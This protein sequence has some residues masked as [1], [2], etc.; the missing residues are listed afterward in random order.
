MNP[1]PLGRGVSNNS[2]RRDHRSVGDDGRLWLPETPPPSPNIVKL[3]SADCLIGTGLSYLEGAESAQLSPQP[4]RMNRTVA[5]RV[6]SGCERC[7]ECP[8]SSSTR[9]STGPDTCRSIASI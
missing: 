7:G 1:M 9:R 5:A 2:L 4:S 8:Q 3:M 6:R